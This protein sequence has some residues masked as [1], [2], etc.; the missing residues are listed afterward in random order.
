LGCS[1]KRSSFP[2]RLQKRRVQLEGTQDTSPS[3]CPRA[4]LPCHG[5]I[6]KRLTAAIQPDASAGGCPNFG[7]RP[8]PALLQAA[9]ATDVSRRDLRPRSRGVVRGDQ[10]AGGHASILSW[11]ARPD[12]TDPPS[13]CPGLK[14]W[15]VYRYLRQFLLTKQVCASGL[16]CS[17]VIIADLLGFRVKSGL[18]QA[19]LS[20]RRH[21]TDRSSRGRLPSGHIS[22]TSSVRQRAW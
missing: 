10:G 3:P 9:A 5:W 21:Q 19:C 7:A 11:S 20:F 12:R 14:N 22:W 4:G 6:I 17:R 13:V 1:V 2:R 15:L 18:T 8:G 16:I